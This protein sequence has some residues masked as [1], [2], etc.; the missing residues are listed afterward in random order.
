MAYKSNLGGLHDAFANAN[1]NVSMTP[2]GSGGF[3]LHPDTMMPKLG[4]KPQSAA[5]HASVLKAGETSAKKRGAAA[6]ASKPI[7]AMI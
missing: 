3:D 7:K 6:M 2:Q 5:Q 4:K 1:A